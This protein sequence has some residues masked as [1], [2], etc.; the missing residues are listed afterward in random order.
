MDL[1]TTFITSPKCAVLYK[2][3]YITVRIH[4]IWKR[5]FGIALGYQIVNSGQ[6]TYTYIPF[7]YIIIFNLLS[8]YKFKA[9]LIIFFCMQFALYIIMP[10]LRPLRI[11]CC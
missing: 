4:E 6:T 10:F 8:F 11:K 7:V 3:V 9:Y 1:L 5:G 2:S